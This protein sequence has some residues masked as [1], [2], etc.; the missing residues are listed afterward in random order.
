MEVKILFYFAVQRKN[1]KDCNG[2][3]GLQATPNKK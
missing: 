1:K 2:Q 3:P